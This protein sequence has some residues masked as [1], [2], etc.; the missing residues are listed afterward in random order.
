MTVIATVPL[1]HHIS[2]LFIRNFII[3]FP[4]SEIHPLLRKVLICRS[5]ASSL[6]V[7]EVL[8]YQ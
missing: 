7:E 3:Y 5:Y 8:C 2:F 1:L 4:A 6:L